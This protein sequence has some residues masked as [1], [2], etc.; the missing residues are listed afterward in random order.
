MTHDALSLVD[1]DGG[2]TCYKGLYQVFFSNGAGRTL[3]DNVTVAET[4]VIDALPQR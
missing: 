1:E 3:A 2:R 4:V